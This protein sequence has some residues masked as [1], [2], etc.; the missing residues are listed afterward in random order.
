VFHVEIRQF[1]HVAH[2]FNLTADQLDARIVA[3]WVRGISVEWGDRRWAPERAKLTIYEGSELA[4]EDIGMGRG[5]QN[6]RRGA[7]NV[8]ERVLAAAESVGQFKEAV[9]ATT[10]I[11][12][13]AILALAHERYPGRRVSERLALAEQAVWEL[14]HEGKLTMRRDGESLPREDWQVALLDWSSWVEPTPIVFD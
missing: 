1:P 3:P 6:A 13:P 10:P 5:W 14:L 12:L 8:T 11:G 2:A 7:E 4:P 9:Y